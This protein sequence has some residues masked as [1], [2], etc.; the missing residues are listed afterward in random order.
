MK[1][2]YK[3]LKYFYCF[4]IFLATSSSAHAGIG[5]AIKDWLIDRIPFIG[6]TISKYRLEDKINQIKQVQKTGLDQLRDLARQAIKT[7]EKVEEMYYFTQQGIRIADDLRENLQ[8]G[9]GQKLLGALVERWIGISVNPADYIPETPYSKQLK[10]NLAWDLS[11]ESGLVRQHEYFLQGTRAALLAQPDFFDKGAEQFNQ[12]YQEAVRYEQELEKALSAKKQA[13]IKSYTA[14]IVE[15]EEEI[16]VLEKTKKQEGLTIGDVMQIQMAID[17]K[18][19]IIRE[20]NEKIT[21][22]IEEEMQPTEEQ[23]ETLDQ[24][25]AAKDMESTSNFH[26]KERARMHKKY[27]HLWRFW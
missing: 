24:Q 17:T 16:S 21:K 5:E 9:K 8:S 7:K 15:L 22:G 18:K 26:S 1:T 20:L 6:T 3:N 4:L 25:K 23:Q 19:H 11:A 10:E 13:T 27:S 14:N 2:T 12:A